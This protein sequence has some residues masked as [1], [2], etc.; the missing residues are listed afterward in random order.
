MTDNKQVPKT[1][2]AKPKKPSAGFTI[3]KLTETQWG[4][5]GCGI[6]FLGYFLY[7]F[8]L[9]PEV[10]ASSGQSITAQIQKPTEETEEQRFKRE[11]KNTRLP[12]GSAIS[13]EVI[14]AKT[15]ITQQVPF[16][17]Q[18]LE[19]RVRLPSSWVMSEFARYGLPGEETYNVLTNIARYF[20][21][22]IEDTR[23][24]LWVEAERMTRYMTAETWARA[25]MIKRG[26]SPEVLQVRSETDIQALYVDVRDY[27]S[28]AMRTRFIINGDTMV[29]VS[30]GVPVQSYKDAKDIMGLSLNSFQFMEKIN[31]QVEE[32]KDYKLLNVV[33]FQHYASWLPK[34]EYTEST[35]KPS[36]ELH[37]PQLYNNPKGDLLQGLIIINAWRKSN[38]SA[39]DFEM[40]VIKD[41]LQELR[42]TINLPDKPAVDLPLHD[43]FL[44][45]QRTQYT[46]LVN[47]YIRKSEFDIIKDDLAK[48]KQEVWITVLDNDYYIVYLTLITPLLS[49]NYV[50]WAQNMAAYDLLTKSLQA[51]GPPTE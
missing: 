21:P 39:E 23:P 17:D 27:R 13:K 36:I 9:F 37:N 40:K 38:K 34:N 43:N 16:G 1:A 18:E 35:L 5:L 11:N 31:R 6:F 12:D 30:Y 7:S 47:T 10:P 25:Y 3:P 2:A 49:M 50:T 45:I 14:A 8:V 15:K 44:K 28:Y 32:I 42:M 46:A 24:F 22:A 19:F 33:N 26:I 20:G 29:M 48:T 4:M 51:K 41:R